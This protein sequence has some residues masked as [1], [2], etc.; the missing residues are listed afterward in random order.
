MFEFGGAHEESAITCMAFDSSGRRLLKLIEIYDIA[1][2]YCFWQCFF[3]V[4]FFVFF[5]YQA[6]DGWKRWLP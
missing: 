3:F 5:F 6:S 1:Y 2:Y 4:S